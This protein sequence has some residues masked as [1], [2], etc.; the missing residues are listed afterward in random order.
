MKNI[1][2]S[3]ILILCSVIT[4]AN[5]VYTDRVEYDHALKIYNDHL[6]SYENYQ[7]KIKFYKEFKYP[8]NKT[9]PTNGDEWFKVFKPEL[10]ILG[11]KIDNLEKR[12]NPNVKTNGLIHIN[13][14]EDPN[15]EYLL[16]K[17]TD[18]PMSPYDYKFS[19]ITCSFSHPGKKPIFYEPKKE[20]VVLEKQNIVDNVVEP[21]KEPELIIPHNIYMMP[22]GK[23][24]TYEELVI[25]YPSMKYD[26]V[27]KQNLIH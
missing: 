19:V 20:L 14:I 27:F 4:K 11:I 16:V 18:F 2:L 3:L 10:D 25:A 8:K 1:V 12:Y 15:S 13:F 23:K 6:E 21:K 9:Y 17:I 5:K 26:S 24:Y 7:K 22:D